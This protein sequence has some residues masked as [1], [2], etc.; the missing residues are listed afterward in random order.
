MSLEKSQS[1]KPSTGIK[2][3][4][5]EIHRSRIPA[6]TGNSGSEPHY[7]VYKGRK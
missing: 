5:L 1:V 6:R 7:D 3:F 2:V 4:C